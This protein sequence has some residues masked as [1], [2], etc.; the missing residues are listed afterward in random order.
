MQV[1]NKHTN[2]R[3]LPASKGVRL[4]HDSRL[5]F[6]I[7][8]RAVEEAAQLLPEVDGGTKR[9]GGLGTVAG[10]GDVER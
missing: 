3:R 7:G 8:R 2:L 1:Q 5:M 9:A 6:L 10:K 4:H